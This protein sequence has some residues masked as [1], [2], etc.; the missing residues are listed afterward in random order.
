[1]SSPFSPFFLNYKKVLLP[2]HLQT[3]WRQR[4]LIALKWEP[5]LYDIRFDY[6]M[7]GSPPPLL[8]LIYERQQVC[9]DNIIQYYI[10]TSSI[11]NNLA[12][13]FPSTYYYPDVWWAFFFKVRVDLFVLYLVSEEFLGNI[14]LKKN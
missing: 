5:Q 3:Q 14:Q 9:L 12:H 8:H 6:K 13:L 11:T 7:E 2:Y 10:T 1:M 4:W